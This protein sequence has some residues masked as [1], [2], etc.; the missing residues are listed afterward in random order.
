MV[1]KKIKQFRVENGL[2]QAELAKKI[3]VSPSAV[4]M[5]EQNRREPDGDTLRK[6]AAVLG[7]STDELLNSRRCSDVKDV[8]D[9][10]ARTLERQPGLMFNG[11]P[12]T[13]S[14]REKLIRAIRIATAISSQN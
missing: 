9:D 11:A 12:L 6:L 3:G 8:I 14:D 13:R 1:G 7:C 4:G 10:L 2:T 5:Y